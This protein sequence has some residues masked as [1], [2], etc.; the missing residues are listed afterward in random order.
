MNVSNCLCVSV[1]LPL[2]AM[3]LY[4]VYRCCIWVRHVFY[5]AVL[6]FLSFTQKKTSGLVEILMLI[7]YAQ[8]PP[9]N[10]HACVS[11]GNMFNRYL[12]VYPYFVYASFEGYGENA[13]LC[14][15][16][17]AFIA[18]LYDMCHNLV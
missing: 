17:R 9:V 13:H 15:L 6:V 1:I 10:V 4:V 2:T 8:K 11:S 7:A 12:G 3:Q 16:A 5:K 18:G 14:R